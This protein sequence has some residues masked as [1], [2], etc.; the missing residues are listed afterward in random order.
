MLVFLTPF[1]LGCFSVFSFQPYN[2]TIINFFIFPCFFFILSNIN[3]RSKNRYR[4]K[5]YL[6]NLFYAGYFFG[7]GFFLTGTYWISSSLQ[8]DE[9]FKAFIPITIILIPIFLGLFYGLGTLA[10]GKYLKY[11]LNSIF[12]F[13][14]TISFIDFLRAKMFTGFP[15]NLWAYSWSWFNEIIQ[16][17]NPIGLFA[18]NLLTI[19]LFSAFSIFFVKRFKYKS[20]V[21]VIIFIAFF[22]N[23]LYGNYVLNNNKIE[24]KK[25]IEEGKYIYVKIVSPN[26]ELKY[27]LSEEETKDRMKKLIKY[28]NV[29]KNRKTLFIWPEGALSG[30]YFF[31]IEKYKN[32]FREKFS[33]EHLIIFGINTFSKAKDQFF[34]SMVIVD[35][36]LDKKFQYD[37]IKLVPFG[38]FLPFQT[39]LEKIGLKK[40]TE[41]FGSFSY[42]NEQNTF[43]YENLNILPLICY[44]IIFPE[45]IQKK[46]LKDGLLV[47]ISEDGWF[48]DTIGPYQHFSKSIFR[49]VESD[50]F[51]LRSANRGI[52]AIINNKGQII[53]ELKNNETGNLEY[54]LPVIEK[55]GGNKNDLIFFVLLFTYCFIFLK[56]K[57][58]D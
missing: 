42:G 14:A 23:Y 18:F 50:S 52:S 31:E 45:L 24:T 33:S 56:Y 48:G 37:K 2:F 10:C 5:P 16:I 38:E 28:S 20:L 29:E 36:N 43:N 17:L 32:L 3:K 27:N 55:K 4:K 53:K 22:S 46:D 49:A 41:G 47:N 12:L 35:N 39:Q 6:I 54:R 9:S 40:I 8:F 26:F 34:N 58:N 21:L 51:V 57:K 44:E 25:N 15:W 13:C 1:F 30:K 11:D 19:T 7:I